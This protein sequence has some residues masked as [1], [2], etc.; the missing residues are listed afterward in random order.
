[1][2]KF[3]KFV[4]IS[5]FLIGGVTVD[6]LIKRSGDQPPRSG[7]PVNPIISLAIVGAVFAVWKYKPKK[8]NLP[9]LRKDVDDSK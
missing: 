3:L 8:D 1:M 4:I 6:V 9:T 2:S 5:F 7:A